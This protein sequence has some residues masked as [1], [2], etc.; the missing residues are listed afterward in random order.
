MSVTVRCC[1]VIDWT[2]FDVDNKLSGAKVVHAWK[3]GRC[4]GM[5]ASNGDATRLLN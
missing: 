3:A 5:M 4:T 1:C 2:A